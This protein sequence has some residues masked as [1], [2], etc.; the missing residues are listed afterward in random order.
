MIFGKVKENMN[1]VCNSIKENDYSTIE[2]N[3]KTI[4]IKIIIIN[5]LFIIFFLKRK[6]LLNIL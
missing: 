5:F 6:E 1:F 3:N 2:I 4:F